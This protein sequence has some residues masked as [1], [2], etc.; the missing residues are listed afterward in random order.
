MRE[1]PIPQDITNYRFHIVGSMTLKQFGELALGCIIGFAIYSTNLVAF[2]KFPLI[3]I[4]VALG[5]IA[6]FVPIAERPLDHWI[7]TFFRGLYSPTLY[8]WR[9]EES[10]PDVFFL[11]GSIRV[12]EYRNRSRFS[13]S[14]KRKSL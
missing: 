7:I 3:F 12:G 13:P 6:A 1:H 4:F 9:R 11:R 10:P 14:S 5:V 2:V 8:F